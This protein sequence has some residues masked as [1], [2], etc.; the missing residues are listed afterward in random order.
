M[1]LWTSTYLEPEAHRMRELLYCLEKNIANPAIRNIQLV[2]E[3]FTHG[4]SPNYEAEGPMMCR[5][6]TKHFE[7]INHPK[8]HLIKLSRRMKF[9]DWFELANNLGERL[10]GD[11]MIVAN[12]DIY[13]DQTISLLTPA[14][15]EK[16]FV[17]L[18]RR[19]AEYDQVG[20]PP[21]DLQAPCAQDAWAFVTP[22]RFP[23]VFDFTTGC[24]GCDNR[25]AAEMSG[26]GY[27]VSNPCESVHAFHV[28]GSRVT[29]YGETVPGPHMN[30]NP[31]SI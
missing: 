24:R 3:Y 29:H 5:I 17:C 27:A 14:Y 11:P 26:V 25:V 20:I 2:F 19:H 9:N 10:A 31:Q 1:I 7:L 28:H 18:S 15:L 12:A 8:V 22:L 13:F 23:K 16:R 30:V 6:S 21:V 4:E